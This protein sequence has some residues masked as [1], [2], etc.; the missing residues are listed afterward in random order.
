MFHKIKIFTQVN[1][2][3]FNLLG[4][5]EAKTCSCQNFFS[6]RILYLLHN[7]K[8]ILLR[9]Y[10]KDSYYGDNVPQCFL[11]VVLISWGNK[12]TLACM[13]LAHFVTLSNL[14]TENLS[15]FDTRSCWDA[16]KT[17]RSKNHP[18]WVS[19]QGQLAISTANKYCE[20]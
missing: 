16:L 13:A 3:Y 11:L 12:H 17:N 9:C 10:V 8:P 18:R 5:E 20:N 6:S 2:S 4:C 7:F 15:V 14:A 19:I 1:F